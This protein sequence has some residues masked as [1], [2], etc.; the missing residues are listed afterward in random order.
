MVDPIANF[1]PRITK[2]HFGDY[3][4]PATSPIQPEKFTGYHTGD[5]VEYTD[6]T[7]D[8][9]VY[10]IVDATVV[11]AS[12]V[13]GYGGL[14]VL[15]SSINGHDDFILYGHVRQSTLP[16]VG[17]NVKQGDQVGVLGTGLSHET[18]GERHHLHFAIYTGNP[19]DIRGYVQNKDEL[20]NWLNPLDLY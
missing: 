12:W 18:D 7:D 16:S 1:K 11:R 17:T 3:I 10:A 13:S 8:V 5:D 2:K 19:V 6:T 20:S 14:L 4:T 9:P 15:K